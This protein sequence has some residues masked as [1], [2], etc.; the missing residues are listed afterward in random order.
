MSELQFAS[1]LDL[2][3]DINKQIG[4][5]VA[6]YPEFELKAQYIELAVHE[7]IINAMSHGNGYNRGKSVFLSYRHESNRLSFEVRD[8]GCGFDPDSVPDPTAPE[9]IEECSGRGL[10]IIRTITD[11]LE[12]REGGRI[13]CLTFLAEATQ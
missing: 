2:L 10:F 12:Y 13:C 7:A 11:E 8:E 6:Q 1:Q 9:N 3:P 4:G 5:I